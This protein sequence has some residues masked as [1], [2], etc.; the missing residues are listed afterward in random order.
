MSD[1]TDLLNDAAAV[2]QRNDQGLYTRP[3]PHLYPHQWLWDSCFTAI[4]LRHVDISRAKTELQSLLRGQW[5]NGMLPNMI[6]SDAPA[7]VADRNVWR[8]WLNPDAPSDVSTSGLTQPPMLADAVVQV[9][10]KLPMAERR[11][12]Y[13]LML[14]ALINYHEW[15][16]RERDPH[17]EGLVLLLHPWESGLDNTPPWMHELHNHLM[18]F[19]IRAL[20]KVK[21]TNLLSFVRR[22]TLYVA[23]G[24][25]FQMTESLAL[26]DAQLRLRRKAYRTEQMLDHSLFAIEDLAFNSILIRANH[27][28]QTIAQAIKTDLPPEL[29][30]NMVKTETAFEDLWDPYTNQ[31]YPRDFVSHRLIKESSIATLL[32]LY[33]GH[34]TAERAA[35]LVKLIENEHLFATNYPLPSAP[36]N[37]PTFDPERYWQG[38]TW[39]NMNWLVIDGLKRYGYKDHAQALTEISLEMVA[40]SGFAEYFN[41][42]TGNPLGAKDF[43]WTAALTIDFIYR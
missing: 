30:A 36:V 12:W 15:L 18:P 31:Y 2:L 14:P 26:F 20:D 35:Q 41:P 23:P 27:Q 28:L 10:S 21:L 19:W 16:Y 40:Q 1:Y 9:G 39:L 22:D 7:Y 33:A 4:G 42:I 3:A 29:L 5:H 32:P 37:G 17:Q 24:Q 8:S 38:P 34:I 13:K 43:S 11:S 25:R 6:M